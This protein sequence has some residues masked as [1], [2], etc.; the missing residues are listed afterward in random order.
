ML[1]HWARASARSGPLLT[2]SS[3]ARII[4]K[5]AYERSGASRGVEP[6]R[7]GSSIVKVRGPSR[8]TQKPRLGFLAFR[9]EWRC[10]GACCATQR[11][12]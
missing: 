8:F 12:S 11:E 6:T 1:I 10:R 5:S 7:T 2:R 3:L 4:R 9:S